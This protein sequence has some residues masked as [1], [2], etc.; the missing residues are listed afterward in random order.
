MPPPYTRGE[1]FEGGGNVREQRKRLILSLALIFL[2]NILIIALVQ[3]AQ[4]ATY[5]RGSSGQEVRTIQEKLIRWG[6]LEGTA[7]GI[8][9]SRTEAAV[10]H[11]QR[12]NGLTADGIVGPATLKA[13][14]MSTGGR[15]L[16][17]GEHRGAAGPGD[18]RRGPGG[19]LQRPG[20]GGGGDPQPGGAPLLPQTPWPGW[21]TS[22]GPFTCMVD[23]QIDQP[24]AD[25]AYRAARDALNGADPSGGPSTT[26]TPAPPPARGSGAG[27]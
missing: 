6:Y 11:F 27:P 5:R 21:C 3:T 16:R 4:A 20:G 9:G 13:L 24:V 22:P 23:G 25:S 8:F 12:K 19:A 2:L 14:G 18:L 26:S 15:R 10:K 1:T 17:P 7:D